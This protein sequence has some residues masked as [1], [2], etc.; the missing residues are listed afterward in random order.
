MPAKAAPAAANNAAHRISRPR[1]QPP[2][3]VAASCWGAANRSSNSM[4]ASPISRR[5]LAGSLRRQRRSSESSATGIAGSAVQFG[6][7]SSTAA[8]SSVTVEPAKTRLADSISYRMQPK[9][10]MSVRVSVSLPQACSGDMYAAVPTM[11][12]AAVSVSSAVAPSGPADAGDLAS[13]KSSTL[14]PPAV[15][16]MFSGFRSRCTIPLACAAASASATWHATASAALNSSGP[17]LRRVASVWPS[18]YSITR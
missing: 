16:M 18:T 10:Q 4:R 9:D 12:P 17:F 8:R 5:R 11:V 15:S 1:D 3:T 6:S 14:A 13:P 7:R 2:A